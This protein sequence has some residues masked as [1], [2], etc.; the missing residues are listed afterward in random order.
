M[1][2]PPS[3]STCRTT[4]SSWLLLAGLLTSHVACG[5][6]TQTELAIAVQAE[7]DPGEPL[8]GVQIALAGKTLAQSDADGRARISLRGQPGDVIELAVRCPEGFASPERPIAVVLRPLAERDKVPEYRAACAPRTR[9]LVVAVRAERG[10][11]LP[12][13]YLG[14]EIA[15]TDASGAAHALLQVEPERAV[16]LVLDTSAPEHAQ[17][18]PRDPELK[19]VMPGRDEVAVFEQSF[20]VAELPKRKRAVPKP[21]GPIKLVAPAR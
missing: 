11:N 8:A 15:R 18:R 3:L 21:V 14:K 5:A 6:R 10:A 1:P 17:L 7:R 19:L 9:S 13:R 2:Q 12:L 16:S 20:T 4:H